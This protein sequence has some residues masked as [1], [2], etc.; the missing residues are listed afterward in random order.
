MLTGF[1]SGG[2]LPTKTMIAIA[3]FLMVGI[4][5]PKIMIP[6]VQAGT[7]PSS[8]QASRYALVRIGNAG[9]F[10]QHLLRMKLSVV[11]VRNDPSQCDWGYREPVTGIVT[12]QA[13]TLW[14][15]PLETWEV[16]CEAENVTNPIGP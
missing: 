13:Y 4:I 7:D 14:A 11:D 8:E 15:I 3:G 12:V 1:L 10:I 5:V 6:D 16:T 2:Q 9:G